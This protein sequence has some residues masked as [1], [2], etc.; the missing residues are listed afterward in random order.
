MHA[1]INMHNTNRHEQAKDFDTITRLTRSVFRDRSYSS[2]TER[3]IVHA[4]QRSYPLTI[5]L[6][7]V[8]HYFI[9]GHVAISPI[10]LSSGMGSWASDQ[11]PDHQRQGIGLK[12]IRAA[13]AE[14]Q[15]LVGQGCVVLGN[16][17]SMVASDSN[18]TFT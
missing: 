16:P 12:L 15:R 1:V 13:L 17:S 10:T 9:V 18:P 11:S 14:L 5:S 4:L 3:Y 6:V 7:A 2:H 8:E